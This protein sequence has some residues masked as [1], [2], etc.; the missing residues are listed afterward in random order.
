[1]NRTNNLISLALILLSTLLS[2]QDRA[3]LKITHLT[4]DFYI[5]TTYNFF[6]GQSF[7]SNSMYFAGG[8]KVFLFDTPWDSTQTLPLLDSI[9]KR[10][11]KEVSDCIV[12]HFHDDRTAG[13]DILKTKGIRTWSTVQ[14]QKLCKER[15]EKAAA[16]VFRNDTVFKMEKI[17]FET[18]YPGPG[19]APDNIVI[20]FPDHKVLYGGCFVKSCENESLGNIKDA[21]IAEWDRSVSKVLKKYHQPRF[22]IPGHFKWD[23]SSSLH[24]TQKLIRE[25]SKK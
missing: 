22:V 6:R 25:A 11:G 14:T 9:R 21:N 15:N 16:Y 17:S 10:H 4:G 18:Y 7:P 8:E 5:Y 20:W 2:A 19:H 13:L 3:P 24:H 12:T 23:C 1:M